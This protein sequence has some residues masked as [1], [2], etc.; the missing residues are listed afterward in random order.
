[1]DLTSILK[2]SNRFK[3]DHLFEI[4]KKASI[5]NN[6]QLIS[7]PLLVIYIIAYICFSYSLDQKQIIDYSL[8][9]FILII[10]LIPVIYKNNLF[11]LPVEIFGTVI[12]ISNALL[13]GILDLADLSDRS[14][15]FP[16]S[17][18]FMSSL[19]S[20]ILIQNEKISLTVELIKRAL[21]MSIKYFAFN[22]FDRKELADAALSSFVY[23]GFLHLMNSISRKHH[24]AFLDSTYITI[25]TIS[26]AMNLISENLMILSLNNK[27]ESI[28]HCSDNL[29]QYFKP[30]ELNALD[31][32]SHF[33]NSIDSIDKTLLDDFLE[34]LELF[35]TC[36]K[37]DFRKRDTFQGNY[38]IKN[39]NNL[40]NDYY[41]IK[42]VIA[43][44]NVTN[45]FIE[46]EYVFMMFKNINLDTFKSKNQQ[47]KAFSN[48]LVSSLTHEL[49]NPISVLLSYIHS[50]KIEIKNEIDLFSITETKDLIYNKIKDNN[51]IYIKQIKEIIMLI[52]DMNLI[53][54]NFEIFSKFRLNLNFNLSKTKIDLMLLIEKIY[55][56]KIKIK[57]NFISPIFIETDIN[58]IEVIFKNIYL[59]LKKKTNIHSNIEFEANLDQD[60]NILKIQYSI[61]N[62]LFNSNH[63]IADPSLSDSIEIIDIYNSNNINLSR[64]LNYKY[65]HSNEKTKFICRLNIPNLILEEKDYYLETQLNKLE[66]DSQADSESD[67]SEDCKV[68]SVYIIKKHE[69]AMISPIK[70]EC[71]CVKVLIVD[72]ELMIVSYLKQLCSKV[73]KVDTASNGLE[74][75]KKVEILS[76]FNKCMLCVVR[77]LIIFMDINMPVLDGIEAAKR[78]N[79]ICRYSDIDARLYFIS[80]NSDSQYVNLIKNISICDGFYSKPI[81]K[82][83]VNNII[84]KII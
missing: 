56:S 35:N 49:K 3:Y 84:K 38:F 48:V 37:K 14:P 41:E 27:K 9:I 73:C 42:F 16:Y 23:Y 15:S 51:S 32:L 12:L 26:N 29:N 70:S 69:M 8:I 10:T 45:P 75:V 63:T 79:T 36:D 81:N 1:M 34:Y 2:E 53:I 39:L 11:N 31:I 6:I 44:L 66:E 20:V 47:M 74:A 19:I 17:S 43:S 80:G 40:E 13:K 64:L 60:S 33:K 78:I 18:A 28:Y 52:S 76:M 55:Q 71:T 22:K 25:R 82:K 30:H 61:L 77:N 58:L 72:D 65:F 83:D 50:L 67:I 24:Q 7:K 21:F 57:S 4:D 5:K 46:E 54:I 68:N 62:P 59:I